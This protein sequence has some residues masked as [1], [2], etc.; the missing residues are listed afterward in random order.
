VR[1]RARRGL[2]EGISK[3]AALVGRRGPCGVGRVLYG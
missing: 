3:K 2:L 1:P